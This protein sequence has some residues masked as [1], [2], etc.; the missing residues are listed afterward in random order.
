[1][2]C[3]HV[4][5]R[6]V[7][8][9]RGDEGA[10]SCR[11]LPEAAGKLRGVVGCLTVAMRCVLG[12]CGRPFRSFTHTT[13]Q[14]LTA[15]LMTLALTA[16]AARDLRGLEVAQPALPANATMDP[17]G[18]ADFLEDPFAYIESGLL[19]RGA[20]FVAGGTRHGGVGGASCRVSHCQYPDSAPS[21]SPC[22][23][24]RTSWPA[25]LEARSACTAT[26]VA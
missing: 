12:P 3:Q 8:G 15:L 10:G 25:C 5:R 24:P 16:S 22:S 9:G 11:K 17:R 14:L 13:M 4:A 19:V 7:R 2:G 26:T 18:L 21:P 6:G 23:K 1:M 20:V